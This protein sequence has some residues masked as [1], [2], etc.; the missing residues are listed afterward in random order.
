M[1]DAITKERES[2]DTVIL[3]PSKY[4]VVI[5]NDN[6][7]PIDFVIAMLM[8]VFKHGEEAAYNITMKIHNE[9]SGIAGVYTYEIAEQ[10]GMEGQSLARQNGYPLVLKVEAE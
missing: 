3:E 6:A 7:T 10:K 9:G 2:V 4:K 1:A 8:K 5:L